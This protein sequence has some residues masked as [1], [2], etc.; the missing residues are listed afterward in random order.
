M[1]HCPSYNFIAQNAT[2]KDNSLHK[3]RVYSTQLKTILVNSPGELAAL[4]LHT[5]AWRS[6]TRREKID[7]NQSSIA[8]GLRTTAW[9][10]QTR[11]KKIDCNQSSINF[12]FAGDGLTFSDT[13]KEKWL[14][15]ILSLQLTA[16]RFQINIFDIHTNGIVTEGLNRMRRAKSFPW[17]QHN[18]MK[19]SLVLTTR[20]LQHC[21]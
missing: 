11:R 9:R 14:L 15:S 4:G 17:K 7:C 2:F 8:L 19:S 13:L 1:E 6:Q 16:G 5:T 21:N 18:H 20:Q 10:S 3:H 12:Q